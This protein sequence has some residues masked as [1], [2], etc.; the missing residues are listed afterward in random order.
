MYKTDSLKDVERKLL[1]LSLFLGKKQP[2]I[3]LPWRCQMAVKIL[4][5]TA[6]SQNSEICY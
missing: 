1:G 3:S 5:S 2:K 4:S 6:M